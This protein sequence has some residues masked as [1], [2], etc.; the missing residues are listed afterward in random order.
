MGDCHPSQVTAILW[1]IH[2]RLADSLHHHTEAGSWAGDFPLS[3]QHLP[4]TRQCCIWPGRG[5]GVYRDQGTIYVLVGEALSFVETWQLSRCWL[6]ERRLHSCQET[7]LCK[8]CKEAQCVYWLLSVT[9]C[10]VIGTMGAGGRHR[11]CFAF[12]LGNEF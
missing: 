7:L 11:F 4:T 9:F 12:P 2:M 3:I 8:L 1:V 5:A 10:L 6:G